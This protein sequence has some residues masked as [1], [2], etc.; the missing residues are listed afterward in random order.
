MVRTVAA[1]G[2]PADLISSLPTPTGTLSF[3]SEG[4]GLVGWGEFARFT[5]SGPTAAE[6]ID[7]WWTDLCATL[8]VQVDVEG[9]GTGPVVFVSLGFADDDESVAI[10]PRTVLG[11]RDGRTFITTV[12]PVPAL[13][14]REPVRAP[15][16]ISYS[17]ASVSIGD[18]TGAV[19]QA[20]ERIKAGEADKVVL[21]RDLL[22][23]AAEPVDQRFLLRRLADSYPTCWT[24]AV[25]G[26]LG[27]TPEMLLRREGNEVSSR[28]L[29]GTA[30]P[31]RAGEHTTG[32]VATGLLASAKDLSEH[33]YA[34]S[35]VSDVLGRISSDLRVPRHP[36]VLPLANLTHLAT[37]I[38]GTIDPAAG[39]ASS[40]LMLAA[41]LHPT[42]AVG[43]SPASAAKRLIAE[44]EPMRRGRYA[45]PV[46]WMSADGD[47]EFGIALRCAQV[48]DRQVRM[49]AGCGIMA[50]SDPEVEAREAQI[51]MIPIRDAL[52]G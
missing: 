7:R 29:A 51:K 44:L 11:C 2:L 42:A 35:S 1:P 30:W 24:F 34:V 47:G 48:S 50:G 49:F 5:T 38:H 43:G 36:H 25:D 9:A 33:A 31:E 15:G 23:T 13:T 46:G 52:E 37:D 19:G 20:V 22:A 45:A 6:D 16:Q 32:R 40:A 21:A 3:V 27:A 12:G 14:G 17:D 41:R 26:L 28:V 39:R 18:Y 4:E 10:V 8:D